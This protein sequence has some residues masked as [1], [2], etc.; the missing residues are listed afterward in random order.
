M[1]NHT[2]SIPPAV[3]TNSG[4][5][6]AAPAAALQGE[7][8]A[9]RIALRWTLRVLQHQY[10]KAY[11]DSKTPFAELCALGVRV[12]DLAALYQQTRAV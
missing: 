3:D 4:Y 9:R 10:A 6:L 12:R 5:S 7:P 11:N 1:Q 8:S 2:L